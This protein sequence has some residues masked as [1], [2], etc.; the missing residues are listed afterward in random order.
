MNTNPVTPPT[1]NPAPPPVVPKR[2]RKQQAKKTSQLSKLIWGIQLGMVMIL[3]VFACL[4]GH[5]ALTSQKSAPTLPAGQPPAPIATPQLPANLQPVGSALQPRQ[6]WTVPH[7]PPL[8][9]SD[10]VNGVYT[11][12]TGEI[13]A[14][15]WKP[16]VDGQTYDPCTGFWLG[17]G[18]YHLVGPGRIRV[19]I[20]PQGNDLAAF[21]QWWENL[22]Q[23]E[24]GPTCTYVWYT[25]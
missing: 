14:F 11:I 5:V 3:L 7:E 12:H 22:V 9:P 18:T 2:S 1:T 25:K 13:G 20:S 16:T 10:T 17:P 24:A 21:Q 8:G 4:A 15:W 6:L 19:W 23:Q